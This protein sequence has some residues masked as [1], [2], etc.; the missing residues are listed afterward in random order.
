MGK[1]IKRSIVIKLSLKRNPWLLAGGALAVLLVVVVAVYWVSNS[2]AQEE[3]EAPEAQKI[4]DIQAGMPFQILIPA[5]LPRAFDR[6]NVEININQNGPGG[7]PL[8]LLTYH[9]SKNESLYIQEWVPVNPEMET[10]SSSRPIETKWGKGW[11]LKEGDALAAIWADIGPLRASIYTRDLKI[12]PVENLLAVANNMGPASNRQVFNFIVEPPKVVAIPP[13]PP[14]EATLNASG[15]QEIVLVITPGGYSPLRFSVKQN[16]PV[17]LTFRAL[18]EVGCG[19]ELNLPTADGNTASLLL[20][21]PADKQE[22][23]FTPSITG[24][25]QFFCGHA[26]YRGLMVVHE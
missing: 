7:E 20:S 24:E 3:K 10:L 8:V 1:E 5:Y 6:A 2:R 13:A 22:L 9:T 17:K 18:G 4:L 26:M 14:V 21:G 25:Y 23:I 11:L 15:Q 12:L 16:A 19:N